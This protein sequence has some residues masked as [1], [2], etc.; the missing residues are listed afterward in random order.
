MRRYIVSA[1]LSLFI[2]QSSGAALAN[3]PGDSNVR[4][5]VSSPN[6]LAP[7]IEMIEGSQ[8]FAELTG[9][10]DRYALAHMA[11]PHVTRRVIR[12]AAPVP[13]VSIARLEKPVVVHGTPENFIFPKH[14]PRERTRDPLARHRAPSSGSSLA[15]PR[16][17]E[18][19]PIGA[20]VVVPRPVAPSH[21]ITS[22]PAGAIGATTP[23]SKRAPGGPSPNGLAATDTGAGINPWWTY[24]TRAIP[25]VGTAMVNIGTGNLVVQTTD[26]DIPERGVPLAFTRTYNSQSQHDHAGDDGSEPAIFGNLWTNTYDAHIIF[27]YSGQT[28]NAISVYDEEGTRCDYLPNGNGGW[29]PCTGQQ[30]T[31]LEVDPG[32][33]C[34]YW[35]IRKDGSSLLFHT[36]AVGGGCTPPQ[37]NLG[38]LYAIY[39]RN[40]NNNITFNYSFSGGYTSQNITQIVVNHSDGQSL[41]L[42]FA[43]FSGINELANI[44]YPKP[45]SPAQTL[46]IDYKYD[47]FGDLLEVDKPGND[48]TPDLSSFNVISGDLPQTYGY[49]QPLQFLHVCGPRATISLWVTQGNATDGACVAFDFDTSVRLTDWQ[50]NGVVNPTIN[51]SRLQPSQPSGW[52]LISQQ[53]FVYGTVNNP[54]CTGTSNGTTTM[55]DTDGHSAIWTPDSLYRINQTQVATGDPGSAPSA[56]VSTQEWDSNNNEI[57]TQSPQEYQN[58][59][60]TNMSYDANGNVTKVQLPSVSTSGG[61]VRP[62]TT[63]TYDQYSNLTSSCDAVYNAN[64]NGPCPTTPGSGSIVL[65]YDTLNPDAAEPNGKLTDAYSGLGYHTQLLYSYNGQNEP[66]DYGL[67]TTVKGQQINQPDGSITPQK[68]LTY[69]SYGNVSAYSDGIGTWSVTY[70]DDN[71]AMAIIDPDNVT[72]RKCY[73]NDGSVSATQSALQYYKDNHQVCGAESTAYTHDADGDVVSVTDHFNDQGAMTN[74]FYDGLD[75]LIEVDEPMGNELR[76]FYD[77][78][79]NAGGPPNLN[80]TGWSQSFS[81][82]GD[83]FKVQRYFTIPGGQS[84][85][86]NDISGNAFDALDR[87]VRRFQ[88]TPGS[89][90]QYPGAMER[91]ISAY[92]A[93][94]QYGILS[95]TTDPLSVVTTLSYDNAARLVSKSFSDGST[96]NITYVNDPDGRVHKATSSVYGDEI[97]TYDANG[98]VLSYAEGGGPSELHPTISYVYYPNGWRSSL[99]INAG[100]LFN[101]SSPEFTYE[102]QADGLRKTLTVAGKANPFSWQYTPAGRPT[103]QSDPWTGNSIQGTSASLQAKT[104]TFDVGG[105]NPTGVLTGM[106]LPVG[107]AYQNMTHDGEGEVTSFGVG[108]PPAFTPPNPNPSVTKAQIGYDSQGRF[109]SLAGTSAVLGQG[110]YQTVTSITYSYG[111]PSGP[112]IDPYTGSA[113]TGEA[114][115]GTCGSNVYPQYKGLPN[116]TFDAAGREAS[117]VTTDCNNNP[118]TSDQRTYDAENHTTTDTVCADTSN[119]C[120]PSNG[121]TASVYGWAATGNLRTYSTQSTSTS[122]YRF[123]WDGS[124]LLF[125]TDGNGNLI[126]LDVEKLAIATYSSQNKETDFVV[127]D[128]D[129]SGTNVD[130]HGQHGD[131]GVNIMPSY[132]KITNY[133]FGFSTTQLA[134]GFP[135]EGTAPRNPTFDMPRTD[136]YQ[137]GALVLQGVRAYDPSIEQ[138]TTPDVYKGRSDDPTTQWAYAWNAGNPITNQDPSG[139]DVVVVGQFLNWIVEYMSANSLLFNI[140]FSA[141]ETSSKTY[142]IQFGLIMYQGHWL[143]DGGVYEAN[144]NAIL[145]NPIF[146]SQSGLLWYAPTTDDVINLLAHEIGHAW[147][148]YMGELSLHLGEP[149]GP[150]PNDNMAE[151]F[152]TVVHDIIMEELE[153][154]GY[155][156]TKIDQYLATLEAV[157]QGEQDLRI[158]QWLDAN[159]PFMMMGPSMSVEDFEDAID[160]M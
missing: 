67:P 158:T 150:G 36:D 144:I 82:Y 143:D 62:T 95:S 41:T 106:T 91:W 123:H 61:T 117:T 21:Q 57:A 35:L 139:L 44:K 135:A 1:L 3:A 140:I 85:T 66:G 54:P 26:V 38:R 50:S 132:S 152:A 138:W 118:Y 80:I 112:T 8:L 12:T 89:G 154:N 97:Y 72:A 145:I 49:T 93:S 73:N 114:S 141:F 23:A 129:F 17:T 122:S 37:A 65:V 159:N 16:A 13:D 133:R 127:Y 146:E 134:G 86:W 151:L 64:N 75:R 5:S 32:N 105:N 103:S 126:Q 11:M 148:D 156:P 131:G 149:T 90:T 147:D 121:A 69:D 116:L 10:G 42:N 98:D 119:G 100:S 115:L 19:R 20:P 25:G 6:I 128:R 155:D 33:P 60:S 27:R 55:C 52:N 28:V 125:V 153:A 22:R 107:A 111:R 142:T 104:M 84:N 30:A 120:S 88:R 102:Y 70:N 43:K 63:Y 96:P 24:E 14:P 157:A 136:G 2:L 79:Q 68:N 40:S 9:S 108:A 34:M 94:G 56:L 29:T 59:V 137:V 51:G 87:P 4:F 53:N 18:S 109:I 113:V 99:T 71:W 7:L 15:A 48:A 110:N 39:G 31:T 124:N 58:G 78:T 130:Q 101:S 81:G 77:L 45:G 92:D 46:E 47:S 160:F 83:L 74:K 76:Y